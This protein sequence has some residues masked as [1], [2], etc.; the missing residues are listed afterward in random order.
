LKEVP[1]MQRLLLSVVASVVSVV[2]AFPASVAGQVPTQD[3]V[4][5]SGTFQSG[6]AFAFDARSGPSGEN[7]TGT[8]DFAFFTGT[9]TCLDVRQNVATIVVSTPTFNFPVAFNVVDNAATNSP[10]TV[11]SG[12]S[13][14]TPP[15][16]GPC[17][18]GGNAT[19]DVVATGDIAVVDA[20]RFP[21]SKA[22][23]KNGGWRNFGV[24]KN[25]GDCVSF[26]ATGGNNPPAG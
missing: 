14:T 6:R 1:L 26:V 20:P 15:P 2:L 9:V 17:G 3:A 21:T 12:P 13:F 18:G 4:T 23:C 10:D 5:G 22:Q 11:S 7:P 25:Q 24:F 16:V 19:F 8:V